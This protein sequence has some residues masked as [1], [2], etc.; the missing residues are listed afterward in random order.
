MPERPML[1]NIAY[2]YWISEP[3]ALE[4][5]VPSLDCSCSDALST[6]ADGELLTYGG[7]MITEEFASE[8][9]DSSRKDGFGAGGFT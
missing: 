8:A 4:V 1:A 9:I 2:F 7:A 6:I 5:T 3:V